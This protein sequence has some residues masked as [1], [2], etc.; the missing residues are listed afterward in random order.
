M[1]FKEFI[2]DHLKFDVAILIAHL[3]A[4]LVIGF[5]LVRFVFKPFRKWLSK[6]HQI[7]QDY[8]QSAASTN[9]NALQTQQLAEAHLKKAQ[10]DAKTIIFD[11]QTKSKTRAQLI[12]QN[13]RAKARENI[14]LSRKEALATKKRLDHEIKREVVNNALQL[15]AKLLG[16]ELS[17]TDHKKLIE[18]FIQDINEHAAK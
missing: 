15:S 10:Q 17:K 13:A 9:K 6:R 18:E 4:V 11:A 5:F 7:V 12:L 3:I 8:Y 2:N 14:R 1:S 16:R